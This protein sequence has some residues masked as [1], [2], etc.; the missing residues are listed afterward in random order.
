MVYA[1]SANK[2]NV[3]VQETQVTIVVN[4]ENARAYQVDISG[5]NNY[6]TTYMVDDIEELTIS[7][8][9]ADGTSFADGIYKV[10]VTPTFSLT[11]QQQEDLLEFRQRGDQEAIERY[12]A[13]NGLPQAL[14]IQNYNFGILNG[15][16]VSPN[17]HEGDMP[18]PTMMG[19]RT[20]FFA[21]EAIYAS[22]NYLE[23]EALPQTMDMSMAEE[24]QVFATDVIVQGSL[25]VG[26]D[27]VSAESFGFDTQRLKENNLRIHFDDTS[28]GSFPA[29]DWRLVANDSDNGG[30]NLFAIEDATAGR[31]IFVV[32]ADAPANSLYVE[33]DGDVGIKTANPV[34]DLHMVEG[35]TPTVRLEQDG[36]DGFASQTWDIAGNEANFF[37]RDVTNG[38]RLPFKI[39]PGAPTDA[40]YVAA[41]GNIGLGTAAPS[42]K[43]HVKSG[44]VFVEAGN[45]V[46]ENGNLVVRGNARYFLATQATFRDATGGIAMKIDAVTKRVGIGTDAPNHMLELSLDDAVKPGGG[47][48]AAPSDRRLKTNI[49]DY[50]DGLAKVMAIRPVRYNYN[51]KL[52][53]PTD[54]EFI[55]LIA[56]EVQEVAPYA[57]IS[58]NSGGEDGKDYLSIDGTPLTYM[59]I[60]AVQDQQ[61]I[62]NKQDN[63]IEQLEAQLS[64]VAQLRQEVAALAKVLQAQATEQSANAQNQ[65]VT[66][67]R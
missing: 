3:D 30:A 36:S 61:A 49:R 2:S 10:A 41:D 63:R 9:K 34:V 32:E 54:K 46:V 39:K 13:A 4:Q 53:M 45:L 11:E 15:K 33:S 43:L 59:L 48:W 26:I 40:L 47:L 18:P 8:V 57:V 66:E 5:P 21:S 23:I 28:V 44:N 62:I 60:N 7:P 17:K 55:G 35:N 22:L 25:C 56:Q 64:E 37:V 67:E 20:E 12:V 16:F 29:N 65:A 42:D 52:N 38:S 50:E 19:Q 51:G 58:L 1:Q 24:M 14:E 31:R 27:C 6:R